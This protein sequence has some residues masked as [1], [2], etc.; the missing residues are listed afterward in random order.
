[1][2]VEIEFR[3]L[4]S[5]RKGQDESHSTQRGSQVFCVRVCLCPSGAGCQ[6]KGQARTNPGFPANTRR[7][8]STFLYRSQQRL[9]V[10]VWPQQHTT[11]VTSGRRN[12]KMHTIVHQTHPQ[13]HTHITQMQRALESSASDGWPNESGRCEFGSGL[14]RVA[15]SEDL[16]K[17]IA[18][19]S[20]W[21][22]LAHLLCRGLK[23]RRARQGEMER[24]HFNNIIPPT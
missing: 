6:T 18:V 4:N 8:N 11:K 19:F 10:P 12:G 9:P 1:M 21:L 20:R 7:Y 2:G 14:K 17:Q 24:V 16:V 23:R 5:R 3:D 13:T 15:S 22:S